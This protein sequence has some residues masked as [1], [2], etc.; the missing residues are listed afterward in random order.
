MRTVIIG[1]R[2]FIGA[3]LTNS[4]MG[5]GEDV[6]G[7]S[8]SEKGG[9]NPETGVFPQSIGWAGK[10]DCVVHLSQS[11]ALSRNP[12]DPAHGLAV[13]LVS[14]V[15]SAME[16][17][18]VGASRFVYA[19]SGSVYKSSFEPL[20]ESAPLTTDN[21]YAM[22]KV[23]AEQALCRFSEQIDICILRFFGVYG[24]T[25]QARLIPTLVHKIE[26]Q[27]AITL[28]PRNEADEDPDGF[29]ISLTHV[30]DAVKIIDQVIKNGGC[31]TLNVAGDDVMS[32][33]E[34]STILGEH[35]SQEPIFEIQKNCRTGNLISDNTKLGRFYSA[36]K[37]SFRECV[38]DIV[39]F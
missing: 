7:F 36:D 6:V 22:S 37:I 15:Q 4:L 19:S 8:S 3:A 30:D 27:Q 2:G 34:I 13:N 33:K 25:Q 24:P 21:W 1:S 9:I 26:N 5:S 28:A 10:A 12:P 17:I 31:G 20:T 11:P 18:R 35:L 39:N 32:I 23:Y 38:A 14:A 29:E 16:A